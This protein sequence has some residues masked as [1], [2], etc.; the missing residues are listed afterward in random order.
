MCQVFE[1]NLTC[2]ISPAEGSFKWLM[3]HT[4][5]EEE[6]EFLGRSVGIGGSR[7]L[8]TEGSGTSVPTRLTNMIMAGKMI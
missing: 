3:F 8:G 4:G 5:G 2:S 7:P 1:E 6:E